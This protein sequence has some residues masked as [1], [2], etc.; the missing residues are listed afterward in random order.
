MKHLHLLILI[1]LVFRSSL[2]GQESSQSA[3]TGEKRVAL[4]IG[5]GNYLRGTLA[6]PENDARAMK[7]ILTKSGFE[8]L[9]YENLKQGQM[10][11]AID[12]FGMKLKN[13]DVGLFY[14]AGHGIQSRGLNYLIPVDADLQSEAQVEYDCVQ[15]DRVLALMEESGAKIKIVILDACR[16]NPFERSWTRASSGKGLATMNAPSGTLIAYSTAPGRTA[17]DGSGKNSLYTTALLENIIIPDITILQMFQN[18]RVIVS[19]QSYKDQIPWESTSLVGDFYFRH[20][21]IITQQEQQ[22][23]A[24]V[25]EVELPTIPT[26]KI[27]AKTQS[28]VTLEVD[29]NEDG[30][31]EIIAR[32]ICYSKSPEPTI[33]DDKTLEGI[34]KGKFLSTLNNLEPGNTYYA[35]A[36][37][38]NS[39][40]ITYSI[41]ILFVTLPAKPIITTTKILFLTNDS[42][43]SGGSISNDGGSTI[44]SRGV[45]WNNSPEPTIENHKTESGSDI[46]TYTCKISNLMPYTVYYVRAFATNNIETNYGNEI[47]FRTLDSNQVLDVDGN[48][49]NTFKFVVN[50]WMLENLSTTHLNDGTPII[51]SNDIFLWRSQLN[52]SYCWYNNQEESKMTIGA[53]YNYYTVKSEKLCPIG[54][55]VSTDAD[56]K[57]L[58]SYTGIYKEIKSG[59][60]LKEPGNLHWKSPNRVINEHNVFAKFSAL[61]GGYRDDTGNFIDISRSGNW[62]SLDLKSANLIYRRMEYNDFAVKRITVNKNTLG[63]SVRCV[64]N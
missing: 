56:W 25:K 2:S 12:E 21:G 10:K 32:G 26:P 48:I 27:S 4:I 5:N 15:A 17:S 29:I 35:R 37:A 8:V 49:Y 13:F 44:I 20:K 14:Y 6:N 38:V 11:K 9:E 61:P 51:Q 39:A 16:N 34:G 63:F 7:E 23:T 30:G 40:G 62:W 18:V 41:Q 57:I 31:S 55:H 46:G 52:P 60:F 33:K 36:Y 19:Q 59:G 58:T 28:G 53:L 3:P 22:N 54:W 47:S 45:C 42:A 43:I 1:V 24:P 64:K 50:T